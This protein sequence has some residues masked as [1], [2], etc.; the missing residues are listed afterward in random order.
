[1]KPRQ[2]YARLDTNISNFESP[3]DCNT[4]RQN[5]FKAETSAT[6]ESPPAE[7]QSI[8][9]VLWNC[10]GMGEAFMQPDSYKA[11][12]VDCLTKRDKLLKQGWPA[13]VK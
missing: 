1:M 3:R 13:N 8:L 10:Q 5:K 9:P 12:Q 2:G 7:E 6:A 11:L 4:T